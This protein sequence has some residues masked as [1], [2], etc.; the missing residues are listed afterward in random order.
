MGR[1]QRKLRQATSLLF[2]VNIVHPRAITFERMVNEGYLEA[3]VQR[4]IL[5]TLCSPVSATGSVEAMQV[6]KSCEVLP[7]TIRRTCKKLATHFS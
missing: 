4:G 7:V 5:G 1:K 3:P 2:R 6:R